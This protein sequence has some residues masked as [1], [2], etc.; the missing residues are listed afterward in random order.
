MGSR[1]LG[2]LVIAGLLSACG[3]DTVAPALQV[4]V[5]TDA[6][7]YSRSSDEVRP[8]LVNASNRAVYLFTCS[9]TT[10]LEVSEAGGWKDLGAW[11][12]T[13]LESGGI[14]SPGPSRPY[15]VDPGTYSDLPHLTADDMANL[16]PGTYRMRVQVYAHDQPPYDL[17]PD[18]QRV[19]DPFEI[20]D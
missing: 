1:I 20:V 2:A 5:V 7:T 13:C 14:A 12:P 16:A 19:S 15:P 3:D 6:S 8:T 18:D 11:Y 9:E 10:T 4:Q 17:L